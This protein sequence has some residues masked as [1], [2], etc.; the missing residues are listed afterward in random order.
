MR[1][2]R[3]RGER[4]QTDYYLIWNDIDCDRMAQRYSGPALRRRRSFVRFPHLE[5]ISV[6]S[7]MNVFRCL[8]VFLNIIF[9]YFKYYVDIFIVIRYP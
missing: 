9:M 4:V 8:G 1:F 2:V 5:N 7:M 3:L 6:I